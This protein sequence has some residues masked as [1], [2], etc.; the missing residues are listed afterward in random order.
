[1]VPVSATPATAHRGAVPDDLPVPATDP[2]LLRSALPPGF[3]ACYGEV[4]LDRPVVADE[5]ALTSFAAD[6]VELWDVLTSLPRRCFGGDLHRYCAAIGLDE[7]QA[8]LMLVGADH[9]PALYAR[10][11]AYHDGS[12]F[13]LLELNA[14][15]ELGGIEMAQLNRAFLGAGGFTEW[16][17]AH[18]LRYVDTAAILADELRARAGLRSASATPSVAL[19]EARGGIAEHEAV[20][21]AIHEALAGHGLDVVLAEL[22]EVAVGPDGRVVVRGTAVD[23]ALRYFTAGQ[24]VGD[25]ASLEALDVLMGAHASR[26]TVLFTPM[27]AGLFASKAGLALLHEPSCRATLSPHERELVDRVVPW[28]R[29]VGRSYGVLSTDDRATLVAQCT[30]EREALVLKPGVG[31]GGDGVVLGREVDD[32]EWRRLLDAAPNRDYVVQEI[33]EPRDEPLG[34]G[35]AA[36]WHAN[37]GIFV[38]GHGYAGA[39]VRALRASDGSVISFSN[40]G[41]RAACVFTYQGAAH[42]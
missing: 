35:P 20:F 10:A 18:D 19:I 31:Y 22:D 7:R 30:A 14:G 8:E 23:V 24:M 15:S 33:I 25:A 3:D 9:R 21:I 29:L 26:R 39:F 34:G 42:A 37:W 41:T 16:S 4:L 32:G 1:M 6:L 36:G 40:P 5:S 28:T 38:T 11:D 13:R 17:A 2:G 27:G 12:T